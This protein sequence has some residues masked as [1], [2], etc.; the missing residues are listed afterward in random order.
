MKEQTEDENIFGVDAWVYCSQHVNAHL[1]GWCGV[2]VRD[3]LGL[4]LIGEH[5]GR[6][7]LEKCRDFHLEIRGDKG[8]AKRNDSES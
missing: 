7:A 5:N 4:G 3:K 8:K 6:A 2:S 1:T